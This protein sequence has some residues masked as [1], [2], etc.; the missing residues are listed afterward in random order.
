MAQADLDPYRAVPLLDET[1]FRGYSSLTATRWE[2]PLPSTW[3]G[4]V[5]HHASQD[6]RFFFDNRG[7]TPTGIIVRNEGEIVKY[8]TRDL[9][10]Q[11]VD[12][13]VSVNGDQVTV[14]IP[15]LAFEPTFQLRFNGGPF[16]NQTFAEKGYAASS[17]HVAWAANDPDQVPIVDADQ[18][19]LNGLPIIL[20]S[21]WTIASGG[22]YTPVDPI[23]EE[24]EGTGAS[25]RLHAAI[26]TV[27]RTAGLQWLTR[28]YWGNHINTAMDQATIKGLS[29]SALAASR[30]GQR[31]YT[32]QA[33]AHKWFCYP[34]DFGYARPLDDFVDIDTSF[35]VPMEEPQIV[36]VTNAYGY[37][38][39][40]YAYRTTFQV[41]GAINVR[42]L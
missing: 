8:Q 15:G 38:T 32:E 1:I 27:T 41:G 20:D 7:E 31:A 25:V 11:G 34:V 26:A 13:S 40:Y 18:L 23:T 36:P 4:E 14:H 16:N 39:N 21:G 29:N 10:F 42:V 28:I 22:T 12:K 30:L 17:I 3:R 33:G 35:K 2:K 19:T 9:G 37:T 6:R 5:V 24:V